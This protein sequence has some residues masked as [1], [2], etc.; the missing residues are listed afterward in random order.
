MK[1]IIV[2]HKQE[3]M[4]VFTPQDMK[5]KDGPAT[6]QKGAK[7]MVLE[8]DPSQEGVFTMRLWFPDGF[9]VKPHWHGQIEHA[10]VLQGTLNI[11]MGDKFDRS[12]TREMGVGS[13]GFW[14]A[15]MKH[16]GWF[17]GDTIL[18]LHGRGPWTVTYVNP[19]DD[20]RKP[21]N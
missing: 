18:Q 12:A 19:A 13:F 4:A 1:F 3:G 6:L 5:W 10:T 15:G 7:M 21:A 2:S 17:K 9:E 16:F 11:G 20:P 8:G 14:P